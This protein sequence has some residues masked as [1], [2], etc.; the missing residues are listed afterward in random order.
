MRVKGIRNYFIDAYQRQE[1]VTDKTGCQT[2]ELVG[3]SFIADEPSIFGKLNHDYIER[4]LEWYLKQSLN[5]NDIP[6]DVPQIWQDVSDRDGFINSNYGYLVYSKE[7]G[8]IR[9]RTTI[10]PAAL[11]RWR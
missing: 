9:R 4:E 6:G 2:I 10:R 5:V 1:F 7:N 11:C 3:A 8:A